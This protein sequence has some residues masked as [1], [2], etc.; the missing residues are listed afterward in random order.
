M[1]E[2][3]PVMDFATMKK[4]VEERGIDC[5]QPILLLAS[6][7]DE[8]VGGAAITLSGSGPDSAETRGRCRKGTC[9]CLT[10]LSG[11]RHLFCM[12]GERK[13]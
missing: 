4:I 12:N 13:K 7:R 9:R 1:I 8:T 2:I 11:R 10:E 3:L 5:A 6:E